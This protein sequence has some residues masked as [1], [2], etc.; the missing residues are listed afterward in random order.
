MKSCKKV[1]FKYYCKKC[2]YG[3]KNKYNFNKHLSTTKHKMETD[4]NILE[5]KK[6]QFICL[7]GKTYKTR[8]GLF[9]HKKNSTYK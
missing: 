7:C 1:A 3:C 4:G 9:K 6:T 8:S 2:D 5:T